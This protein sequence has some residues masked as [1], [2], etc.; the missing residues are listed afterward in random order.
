M[1]IVKI[2]T[3]ASFWPH[4]RQNCILLL[5]DKKN[6]GP[7]LHLALPARWKGDHNQWREHS[8]TLPQISFLTHIAKSF[9]W[10]H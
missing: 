2:R 1:P 4:C 6:N 10:S 7:T 8:H 9:Q 3:S 5:K